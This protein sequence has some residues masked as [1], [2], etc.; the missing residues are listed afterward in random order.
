MKQNQKG[1]S[2]LRGTGRIPVSPMG[3]EIKMEVN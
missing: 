3:F 1:K 2:M